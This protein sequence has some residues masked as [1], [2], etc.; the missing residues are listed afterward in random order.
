M[1]FYEE[2]VDCILYF[3]VFV[4][5]QGQSLS[6]SYVFLS[7]FFNYFLYANSVNSEVLMFYL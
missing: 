5:I 4:L 2:L 7:M 1:V 3:V 6:E